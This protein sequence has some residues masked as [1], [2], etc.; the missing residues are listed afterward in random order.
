MFQ[1]LKK[2]SW[3][4]LIGSA[5]AWLLVWALTLQIELEKAPA[6]TAIQIALQQRVLVELDNAQQ[7]LDRAK[8]ELKKQPK[9]RFTA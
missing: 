1:N 4:L 9:L 8:E 7:D 6:H 2:P 3:W 5:I